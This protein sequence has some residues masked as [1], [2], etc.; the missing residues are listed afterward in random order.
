MGNACS[1]G[2]DCM[3]HGAEGGQNGMMGGQQNGMMGGQQNGMMGG[4]QNGMMGG[5]RNGMMGGQRNGM[6]GGQQSGMMMGGMDGASCSMADVRAM[7]DVK[8]ENTK[9]GAIIRMSA[10]K[11]EQVAQIQ[12]MAQRMTQ[13]MGNAEPAANSPAAPATPSRAR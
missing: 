2:C 9:S 3:K 12:Q 1:Q 13:C 7:A 8:I 5:Q 4:E 6:M 11:A 10:K